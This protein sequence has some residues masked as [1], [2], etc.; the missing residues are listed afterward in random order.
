MNSF[1]KG[2][3]LGLSILFILPSMAKECAERYVISDFDDTIKTYGYPNR[4]MKMGNAIFRKKIN[5]GIGYL[6]NALSTECDENQS[7]TVVTASPKLLTPVINNLM[8]KNNLTNYNLELR[9]IA[10]STL[11]YK[12]KKV[13]EIYQ[14]ENKP[15]ILIGDDT[16][17]D[18]DA[19]F[20]FALKNPSLH[21]ATYIHNV[22][23]RPV[24]FGQKNYI[25]SYEIALHEFNNNRLNDRDALTVGIH[26]L[27]ADQYEIIPRYGQCPSKYE[28]P[29]TSDEDLNNLS[30]QIKVKIEEIC[31]NRV[32]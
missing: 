31:R 19:Y 11:E 13:N 24:L 22:K 14:K 9:P 26:I 3:I 6:I 28:L 23:G 8:K 18:P 25:T 17:K 16:A 29:E 1:F 10:S 27:A 20:D 32:N 30:K 2:V 15:L 5:A 12:I 4:L 21:L 7:F